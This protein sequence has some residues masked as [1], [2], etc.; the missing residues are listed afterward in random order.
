MA[1]S[2]AQDSFA[3]ESDSEDQRGP[4]KKTAPA[5]TSRGTGAAT[6]AGKKAPVKGKAPAAASKTTAAKGKG[7]AAPAAAATAKGKGKGKKLVSRLSQG[8][9][10]LWAH[11]SD[12]L[13]LVLAFERLIPIRVR[14]LG[15]QFNDSDEED[16]D[17]EED[18]AMALDDEDDD[19]DEEE[20]E[21]DDEAPPPKKKAACVSRPSLLVVLLLALA[22]PSTKDN[23]LIALLSICCVLFVFAVPKRPQ[24]KLLSLRRRLLRGEL[25]ARVNPSSSA[26][27]AL[28]PPPSS[29]LLSTREE[30]ADSALLRSVRVLCFGF[31]SSSFAP[32]P[33]ASRAAASSLRK[34]TVQQLDSDESE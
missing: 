11:P 6:T 3:E 4:P 23:L 22:S 28:P 20:E 29:A 17:E 27:S 31:R 8:F 26:W 15:R 13:V 25:E 24:R 7:K 32:A 2:V 18:F 14:F 34:K 5:R 33:R 9:S 16:S 12:H 1:G 19:D 10:F 30:N 21:E